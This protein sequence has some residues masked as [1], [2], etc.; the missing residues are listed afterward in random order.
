MSAEE[1]E[2]YACWTEDYQRRL[3]QDPRAAWGPPANEA[4]L[5]AARRAP[6][7]EEHDCIE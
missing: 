6:P 2:R 4:A 1:W 7:T 5:L 3:N